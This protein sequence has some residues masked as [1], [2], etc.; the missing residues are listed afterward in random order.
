MV[1]PASAVLGAS[2]GGDG[3]PSAVSLGRTWAF[4]DSIA[5]ADPGSATFR[6][7][8]ATQASATA[9]FI[10][11]IADSGVDVGSAFDQAF[12]VDDRIYMQ[13]RVDKTKFHLFAVTGPPID[14]ATWHEIPIVSVDAG[15]E[16]EDADLVTHGFLDSDAQVV[17]S[18]AALTAD[19]DDYTGFADATV[20]R[21]S[22]DASGP[23]TVGG[24][25]PG[26]A[27]H[28]SRFLPII[29]VDANDILIEDESTSG[30]AAANQIITGTG[31][32]LT[33]GAN[34]VLDLWYDVTSARWR[35]MQG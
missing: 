16:F 8:N 7:N 18:P 19:V 6:L 23:W 1:S 11:D 21:L 34:D 29:N 33:L 30:S 9:M 10:S 13:D 24:I 35:V 31:A 22:A 5:Q 26:G 14:N 17:V 32:N 15:T 2:P 27:T 25:A 4:S 20:G 12:G 3:A 28:V